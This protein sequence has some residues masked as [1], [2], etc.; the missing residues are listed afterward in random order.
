MLS[1]L[2]Q[3]KA[4]ILPAAMR[5]RTDFDTQLTTIGNAV[6]ALFEQHCNRRLTYAASETHTQNGAD[7][8]CLSLP[9]YPV[10]SVASLTLRDVSA[11]DTTLDLTE[12]RLDKQ[13]GLLHFRA[14]PGDWYDQLLVVSTG[15]YYVDTSENQSGSL[16]SGATALP[17]DLRSAYY[18]QCKALAEAQG[19]LGAGAA[20]SEK[21][22]T[23][24]EADLLPMVASVLR[25]YRRF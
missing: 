25:Q 2:T 6:Q 22:K 15:G 14:T 7:L 4:A 13:A 8:L 20:A 12:T 21:D 19:I 16:P 10:V 18:L 9:R 17:D 1:S 11:V 3:L 5:S 23:K 24:A